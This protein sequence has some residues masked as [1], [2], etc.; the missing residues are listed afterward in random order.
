[1]PAK[2]PP[3]I[4]IDSLIATIPK[5]QAD[6]DDYAVSLESNDE[7]ELNSWTHDNQLYMPFPF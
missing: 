3:L 6:N 2:N 4:E 1:M 5:R 7:Y